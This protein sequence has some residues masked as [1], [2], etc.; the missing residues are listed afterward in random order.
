MEPIF[1]TA[2]TLTTALGAGKA[3]NWQALKNGNSG[4][5]Q[6]QFL[7]AT[8]LNTWVGEIS[9]L[10]RHVLPSSLQHFHCRNNQLA[11]KALLE[12]GFIE[13]VERAKQKYGAKRIGVFL[14]T[15]TSGILHTELAYR[16]LSTQGD[17]PSQLPTSYSYDHTHDLYSC[18]DY[19]QQRLGLK[20]IS[21]SISTACSSS[22]KVFSSAQRAMDHGL[23]DAAIVGGADTLCFTT[24]Y[25]FNSLQ[26]VSPN[27]CRP[28]DEA[29]SGISIGEAAAYA[30]LEREATDSSAVK[31]LG[32]GESADAHHMSS[33][34]PEGLGAK[35]AM[36]KALSKAQLQ[37]EDI[38]YINLHGTGTLANDD[39]ESK[40]VSSLFGSKLP[41]SSTKGWTGHTL[42]AAGIVEAIFSAMSIEHGFLPQSLNTQN[43]D[44]KIDINILMEAKTGEVSKVMSNSIGFGGSNCSLI[45]GAHS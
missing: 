33:P 7:G 37:P 15:S 30:L 14:G 26:V 1:L 29:R 31:L 20:G 42:G 45:F 16:A 21:L 38:D 3:K 17:G 4:L 39:A 43:I 19:V 13:A 22:A 8:D 18:V 44:P 28:S 6:C 34:H 36:E 10:D 32:I 23:C 5:S 41:C 25:G 24:L 27:I 40:A 35:L 9:D 2:S 12:D 11:D